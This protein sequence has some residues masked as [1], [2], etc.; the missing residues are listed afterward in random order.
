MKKQTLN[1]KLEN[2]MAA[3]AF[4]E[5]GERETALQ[6]AFPASENAQRKQDANV[7]REDN[8]PV[9]RP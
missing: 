5:A 9:L 3:V 4:A 7:I 6:F 1:Q 2:M 8:R